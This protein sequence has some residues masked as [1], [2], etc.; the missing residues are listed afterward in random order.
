MTEDTKDAIFGLAFM[1]GVSLVLY[2]AWLLSPVL[3]IGV[4]G[5]GLMWF[6]LRA[7]S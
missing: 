2:S 5:L 7:A 1:V 3:A 4:F 6:V